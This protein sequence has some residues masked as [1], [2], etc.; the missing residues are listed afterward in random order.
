ME[1]TIP[2]RDQDI[3][4]QEPV[5]LFSPT[6]PTPTQTVYLS[7]IDQTVAFPVET[8]FFF[9]ALK[10]STDDIIE[11][12]KR[13]VS[14][15]FLIPYYFM[16]GRLSFNEHTK[17]LELVCNNKGVFFVGATSKLSLMDLGDVSLPHPSFHHL[18]LRPHA[19]ISLS[20]TPLFTIQVTRFSCGGY[21]IG[22]VTNHSTMDGR[23]AVEMLENLA[24]ICRGEPQL[25]T[26]NLNLDRSCIKPRS[27]PLIKY[28]HPEY[29]TSSFSS[30][31]FTSSSHHM[32]STI[33]PLSQISPT[34][35]YKLF[36]FTSSMIQSLKLKSM[37]HCSSFEAMVAHLWR[38][39]TK[40]VFD[41]PEATSTVLFA[42]D[43]RGKVKP[44]LPC[45][46]IG[47]AVI[48]AAASAKVVDMDERPLSFCVEM[49]KEAIERVSDDEYVRSVIDWLEVYRGVP[50]AGNGNFY[51]SAWWKLP[52]HE[53]DFGH[54]RP[55]YG[56]PVVSAMDE[57]VLLLS[58]ANG[59]KE[60]GGLNRDNLTVLS[61][62]PSLSPESADSSSDSSRFLGLGFV[63]PFRIWGV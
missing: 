17:R 26:T 47:N 39:R 50:S 42:V 62:A 2:L 3:I 19:P 53:L 22:F 31:S 56:G 60:Q 28:Q 29:T 34:H 38:A 63:L 12:V 8:V 58:H 45:G 14:E 11:K 43:I 4:K 1:L 10:S 9:Q 48:T 24:S 46:F 15:S 36:S 54:G 49:V 61:P 7:N 32:I 16:A 13:A 25:K 6:N 44:P 35:S 5:T 41:D 37:T 55:V 23:A 20:D 52:F 21:S 18:I 59:G 57:F 33:S 30:S 40:A 51:V 27:P